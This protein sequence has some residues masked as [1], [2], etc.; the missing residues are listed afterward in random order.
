[1]PDQPRR[2]TGGRAGAIA[3]LIVLGTAATAAA[4][5]PTIGDNPPPPIG[6][7]GSRLGPAPGVSGRVLPTP[8]EA[9]F[10]I[11]GRPGASV[12]RVPS[13]LS[14][15]AMPT[16]GRVEQGIRLP[17]PLPEANVPTAGA[18]GL[19]AAPEGAPAGG[20]TLDAAIEQLLAANLELLATSFEIPQAEADVLTAGLFANPIF[21]ADG[22]LIPYGNYS[23][24]RPGGPPQY[25]VNVSVPLDVS[26]KRR[27]R[28]RVA[29][30]A[31]S[32]LEAQ[33][34]DA[35]RI[36]VD[37][38][39][40]AY[41]DVLAARE[42]LR[43][44]RAGVAGLERIYELTGQLVEQG[45]RTTADL[46]R[47][48]IQLNDARIVLDGA[49]ADLARARNVL[50]ALLNLPTERR[51]TLELAGELRVEAGD[52]GPAE[53]LVAAAIEAR[54]DL[55]AY[56]IGIQRAR[57]DV[58]LAV[59]NRLTD[60]YVLYQPYTF[61]N[62]TPFHELSSHSWALGVTAPIPVMNRN[63]GNIR[64]ARLN[65]DQTRVELSSLQRKVAVEVEEAYRTFR[66]AGTAVAR[67]EAEVLPPARLVLEDQQQL[68]A[69][70][71][72]DAV[73]VLDARREYNGVLRRYRDLLVSYRRSMLDVNT[74]VGRRLL[75]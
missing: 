47:V 10:P 17:A 2:R 30:L 70:G 13:T 42:T 33:F 20:L 3:G 54:P 50:A 40:T 9:G 60:V 24:R 15:P 31:R 32:T 53:R 75:P 1:M 74:A 51:A 62:N 22:Q 65:V 41:V 8:G 37:N 67:F 61:Q 5:G 25:D 43:F 29:R 52:P 55:A 59:A 64:R 38:L 56:R 46:Q 28:V 6:G 18:L 68:Y 72:T 36:Q 34:Q 4:Q 12:P 16:V 63:Q 11:A 49:E 19:P 57:A 21:Y 44:S 58:D 7:I 39:Y 73:A 35:V 71:E 45:A 69:G 14:Q 23:D 27:A 66:V 26:G 48:Q